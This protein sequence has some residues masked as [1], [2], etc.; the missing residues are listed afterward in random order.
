METDGPPM[1]STDPGAPRKA[2]GLVLAC[3][4]DEWDVALDG[5]EEVRCSIR[6]RQFVRLGKDEKLLAAGDRVRVAIIEDGARIIEERL[7]RETALSRLMPGSRRPIE[8]VIIANAEQLVAVASFVEPPLNRRLLDRFLVIGEDAELSCV[9]VLNKIDLVG[10]EW[11]RHARV[12]EDAGYKV[13]PT[14]ALDGRGLPELAAIV[15]GRFSVFAG[16]SGV[17]KSTLL[18]AI[19]PDL[20][21]RVRE[22]SEK[23][24]KGKHTTSNVTVFRLDD[25]TLVADTPGFRELGF[26]RIEADELGWLFPE[27]RE[28]IPGCRFPSC[29]HGPEPDCAVKAALEEGAIDGDRYES[30]LKLV[31]EV[32]VR[33][34]SDAPD[35][36]PLPPV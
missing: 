7:P 19:E 9:V 6:A 2:E 12:Y 14:C 13:V 30:Y 8:Q 16:A 21:I 27:F 34:R 5:G 18:N 11:R 31:D 25:G 23:T 10:D 32:A 20:G 36:G 15:R 17:G 33:K 35:G 29:T 26:W 3:Y 24:R 1:R 28:R 22:V 4:H